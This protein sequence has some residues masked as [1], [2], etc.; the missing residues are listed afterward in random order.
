MHLLA[1]ELSTTSGSLALFHVDAENQ[2]TLVDR[3][4]WQEKARQHQHLFDSVA[5]LLAKA[6]VPPAEVGAFAVGRGPGNYTGLRM[7][8]TAAK[9]L[10]LPGGEPVICVDSGV[11]LA[12]ACGPYKEGRVVVVGDARRQH[13]WAGVVADG[14]LVVD[15]Q[16]VP[17]GAFEAW[18]ESNGGADHLMSPDAERLPELAERYAGRWT[19][20]VPDAEQVG[21]LAIERLA[22][23]EG[24]LPEV[25]LYLQPPV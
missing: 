7:S 25:P 19:A 13:L 8:I 18:V 11:A 17:V 21:K 2:G 5:E 23:G 6:E 1:F 20:G 9:A 15:W 16:L 22:S 12:S 14:S 10:A 4:A 24:G 3:L